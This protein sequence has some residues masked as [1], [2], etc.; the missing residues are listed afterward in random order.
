MWDV[1]LYMAALTASGM[2]VG[3]AGVWVASFRS[4]VQPV[5]YSRSSEERLVRLL[6][7]DVRL[8]AAAPA[9]AEVLC[10]RKLSARVSSTFAGHG[11]LAGRADVEPSSAGTFDEVPAGGNEVESGSFA[12]A[13]SVLS[14]VPE[15]ADLFASLK[16]LHE[17]RV[18]FRGEA[19]WVSGDDGTPVRVRKVGSSGRF[20]WYGALGAASGAMAAAAGFPP[21]GAAAVLLLALTATV[22]SAVDSDTLLIDLSF[23]AV[24]GS[25]ALVLA[26]VSAVMSD[27]VSALFAPAAASLLAGGLLVGADRLFRRL[28]GVSGV[29]MGDVLAVPVA[30]GVPVLVSGELMILP[31]LLWVASV[32]AVAS[33]F[34][35]R[36]RFGSD[37]DVPLAFGP[38]LMW[39]FLPVLPLSPW[40]ASTLF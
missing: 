21:L 12:A 37:K 9:V 24:F 15:A 23:M 18:R 7:Q 40:F 30:F 4:Y 28:R 11:D 34:R 16:A 10:S 2:A 35:A 6:E 26:G 22:V 33:H 3:F 31:A 19:D 32:T 14:L 20:L 36:F 13:E 27:G 38:H 1:G 8:A 5:P 17:D 29:G 25:L 39:A